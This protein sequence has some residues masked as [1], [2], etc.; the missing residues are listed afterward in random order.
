MITT[1]ALFGTGSR[2]E[3]HAV[4]AVILNCTCPKLYVFEWGRFGLGLGSVRARF[5]LGVG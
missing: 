1:F 5:G 2:C 3:R 4:H